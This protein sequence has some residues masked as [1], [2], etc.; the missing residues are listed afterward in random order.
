[1]E[2][3]GYV[4]LCTGLIIGGA[5]LVL[6]FF[7]SSYSDDTTHPALTQEILN[8]YS[9]SYDRP[10]FTTEERELVIKGS[11]EEDLDARW[12]YHF[13][14]PIENR[15]LV[16]ENSPV[17]SDPL[18]AYIGGAR[19]QSEWES[20]KIWAENTLLQGGLEESLTAGLFGDLFSDDD[21][22]SWERAIYDYTWGDKNRGLKGLGHI[23]HLLED[24]TVPDHTR[25]DPHPPVLEL[26]SP[27]EAWAKKFNRKTI[28]INLLNEKPIE[29]QNLSSYFSSLAEN[30]NNNY[31]SKDTVC[32]NA[33]GKPISDFQRIEKLKGGDEYIFIYKRD[34]SGQSY[35]LAAQ[36]T[37]STWFETAT[38]EECPLI[39]DDNNDLVLTDYWTRLSK[40]AVLHGAGVVKLFFDEV[41]KEK[42]TKE[43]YNKNRSWARKLFDSITS[44]FAGILFGIPE[45]AELPSPPPP[46]PPPPSPSPSPTTRTPTAPQPNAFTQPPAPPPSSVSESPPSRATSPLLPFAGVGGPAPKDDGESSSGGSSTSGGGNGE[47]STPTTTTLQSPVITNPA[48]TETRFSTSTIMFQ[49]TAEVGKIIFESFSRATTTVDATGNWTLSLSLPQGTTSLVFFARDGFGNVSSGTAR[50]LFV[51]SLGPAIS[52]SI[53]ECAD[54]IA[55]DGCILTHSS[56][57]IDWTFAVNAIEQKI[58]CEMKSISAILSSPCLGF[59]PDI[60]STTTYRY[61]DVPAHTVFSIKASAEDRNGNKTQI[62]KTIEIWKNPIVINEVGWAGTGESASTSQDEW[63]EIH[64]PTTHGIN[65][66]NVTLHSLT[67]VS[68]FIRLSGAIQP[69]SFYLIERNSDSAIMNVGADLVTDGGTFGEWFG[70]SG[71]TLM[72]SLGSTT[73]DSTSGGCDSW[74]GGGKTESG[75]SSMERFIPTDGGSENA[76][77]GS[78]KEAGEFATEQA[79]NREGN[80][81]SGTPRRQNSIVHFIEHSDGILRKDRTLSQE[82]SPYMVLRPTQIP[83]DRV[84]EVETGTVVKFFPEARLD[85][86]GALTVRGTEGNPAV[87][88]SFAD[89]EFA[90]DTNKDATSTVPRPGDW[91]SI[92][93]YE[94]GVGTID[95][96]LIRYGGARALMST[97]ESSLQ[98]NGDATLHIRHS[99][100]E[101]SDTIGIALVE[102]NGVI[103]ES[104]IQ[105]NLSSPTVSRIGIYCDKC[106]ADIRKNIIRDNGIGVR[107]VEEKAPNAISITDNVFER[108]TESPL[109]VISAAPTTTGNTFVDNTFDTV[110]LEGHLFTP[111][112]LAPDTQY[113]IS[114]QYNIEEGGVLHIPAG[115]VIKFDENGAIIGIGALIVEGTASDPAIFTSFEDDLYGGDTNND[116][117]STLALPGE[118]NTLFIQ[119]NA[120]K[121]DHALIRFGGKESLGAV[122]IKNSS[123]EISSVTIEKNKYVGLLLDNSSSH[124]SHSIIQEHNEPN[125]STETA[126]MRLASSSPT[127]SNTLFKKNKAG[128]MADSL[129]S[130][131]DGGGNVFEE[132]DTNTIPPTLIP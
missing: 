77:W 47:T 106:K 13:Y 104:I 42:Q 84:L 90:G 100:I 2:N 27:Y 65:L 119:N 43:L 98:V 70:S 67:D 57:T 4:K 54:T 8:L 79:L 99:T 71:E 12:F 22:Y 86:T 51:D 125:D 74:C 28:T 24:A 69:K 82:F 5:L 56:F 94:E 115:T 35:K 121:I 72:L 132:N 122:S 26:G 130:I 45:V 85:I 87:F 93:L 49:G 11:I 60:V 109:T 89:D 3:S 16:L 19:I 73:I 14:D 63:I 50:T 38:K 110:S 66:T 64:N 83:A 17:A 80:R 114:G 44:G 6:P 126:G 34:D 61:S 68:P 111:Y 112:T 92:R 124:I 81:I 46:P 1:M 116:A 88:T 15:G 107:I 101:H 9:N 30:S 78:W 105:K 58:S 129:S 31:F 108:N 131:T 48:E 123:P 40:Q 113:L 37:K 59:E 76:N 97:Y 52:V 127:V 25:N 55:L 117:T 20:S 7:T 95:H 18:L 23:L 10:K 96:A 75:I 120:S 41:E 32:Q 29:L 91:V 36:P 21:D 102:G 33:Y 39:L 103:E 128:I 53:R 62:E 118:W